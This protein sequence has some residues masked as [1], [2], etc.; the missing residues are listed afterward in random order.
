MEKYGFV[1]IWFDSYRKMYYVGSHWGSE[2]DGYI[3]SSNRM[4]NAYR[5]RPDDFKRRILETNFKDRKLLLEAEHIWLQKISDNDLGKKYYNMTK[6]LNGHWS[7]DLQKFVTA[8]EKMKQNH[9]SKRGYPP[10]RL[11]KSGPINEKAKSKLKGDQRTEAQ[12]LKTDLHRQKIQGRKWYNDG[13]DCIMIL[14]ENV[15]VGWVL[16]R[17]NVG[18]KIS[19]SRKGKKTGIVPKSAFQKGVTPWNKGLKKE[20]T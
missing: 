8:K 7:T 16:G 2:T 17:I 5:R 12:K 10:P 9:R 4:R 6:H 1:Y 19:K 18:D 3:C 14:P 20:K 13:V 15:P 11:G